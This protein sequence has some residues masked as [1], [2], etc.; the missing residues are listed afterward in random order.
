MGI[1]KKVVMVLCYREVHGEYYSLL[2]E[3]LVFGSAAH[4]PSFFIG[5][6]VFVLFVMSLPAFI[7]MKMPKTDSG[8]W[9]PA[10][11][12]TVKDPQFHTHCHFCR[13]CIEFEQ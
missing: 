11:F 2:D 4:L 8:E 13:V 9:K 3:T 6:L 12:T 5:L 7:V 1:A 10:R